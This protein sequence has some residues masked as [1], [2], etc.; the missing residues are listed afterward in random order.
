MDK[1]EFSSQIQEYEGKMY[2]IAYQVLRNETDAWDAVSEGVLHAYEKRD[3][4]RKKEKFASWIFQI[5]KNEAINILRARKKEEELWDKMT[6][7]LPGEDVQKKELSAAV[8]ELPEDCRNEILLFYYSGLSLKEIAEAKNLPLGT[9]KSRLHR[10]KKLLRKKLRMKGLI[11]ADQK[12][13]M[14]E[15][16][17]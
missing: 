1:E 12:E 17:P 6:Q 10:G 13:D 5:V 8:H 16:M 15:E 7:P 9:V 4:L 2:G 14:Q 3:A 11:L